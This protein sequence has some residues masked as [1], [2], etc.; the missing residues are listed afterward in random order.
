VSRVTVDLR[1]R[2]DSFLLEAAFAAEG[3]WIGVV[4]PSGAGKSTLLEAVAG[5]IPSA[6]DLT[7]DGTVLQDRAGLTDLP[8]RERRVGF[9]FQGEALFPHLSVAGNL[10][11]G[12]PD[13]TRT[14]PGGFFDEVVRVLDLGDLLHRGPLTLSGGQRRR[15]ALGRALLR[16]P[17]LLLLDEPL[18]GLDPA[19][20]TRVLDYLAR[21]RSRF[22][23]PALLVSHQLE[24]VLGLC[25]DLVVIEGGVVTARTR[26]SELTMGEG[27]A[28]LAHLI[29]FENVLEVTVTAVDLPGAT[30]RA[31]GPGDFEV[32]LP[33]AVTRTGERLRF[34]VRAE[35]I[36]LAANHP[37]PTSARNT[38]PG[39]IRS[40][41]PRGQL[42]LVEVDCGLPI[43]SKIT[44]SAAEELALKPGDPVWVLFK[45]HACHYLDPPT[46]G[47]PPPAA[48]PVQSG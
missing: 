14:G 39:R 8:A 45:T 18:T 46:G 10:G 34:G 4:G 17:R 48:D 44:R 35:E 24:D 33:S 40:I 38:L 31:E 9:V 13:P 36:L 12:M 42:M 1:V 26:P 16:E 15:V 20:R 25:D 5:L 7:V 6:G 19:L 11:F 30:V 3:P 47:V 28:L 32:V 27:R 29:G 23:V 37:G 21:C 2:R 41:V 43:L 22:E